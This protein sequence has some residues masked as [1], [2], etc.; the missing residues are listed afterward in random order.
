MTKLFTKLIL[1]K[2]SDKEFKEEFDSY[3]E[4]KSELIWHICEECTDDVLSD[5]EYYN[6]WSP[7]NVTN[8]YLDS[9][10]GGEFN[11]EVVE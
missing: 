8:R 6:D 4:L 10:C 1:T 2:I 3:K 5:C 7:E 11:V 9:F